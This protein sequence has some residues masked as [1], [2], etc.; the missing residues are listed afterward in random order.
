M[1]E[2]NEKS[3]SSCDV[4][5]FVQALIHEQAVDYIPY[6]ALIDDSLVHPV[7]PDSIFQICSV[8]KLLTACIVVSLSKS[9]LVDLHRRYQVFNTTAL[10]G[11]SLYEL[12]LHR[13]G[14]IG[15]S[16]YPG[17]EN[18]GLSTQPL[19]TL[20]T[21]ISEYY[22]PKHQSIYHYCGINYRLIQRI[23][24]EYV[25][26]SFEDLLWEFICKPLDLSQTTSSL[27]K[28]DRQF[29]IKGSD[30]SGMD[31]PGGFNLFT[32]CEAAA[33]IW[34]SASDLSKLMIALLKSEKE[35]DRSSFNI[36]WRD[37]INTHTSDHYRFGCILNK[38]SPLKIGHSG[39][40]PGF[41][42]R[43]WFNPCNRSGV[44]LL[45]NDDKPSPLIDSS[46]VKHL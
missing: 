3:L 8:S 12:L 41:Q 17:V 21:E 6:G 16:G 35:S 25:K 26:A 11:F 9:G 33:G 1:L 44:V 22:S 38:N 46:I 4:H 37:L 20:L 7:S 29:C 23:L 42:S 10:R 24:E 39:R 18:I 30:Q 40:N 5:C 43:F 19:S 34:S 31:L 27:S 2:L 45:W 32:D 13:S 15:P 36:T 28:L 14:I